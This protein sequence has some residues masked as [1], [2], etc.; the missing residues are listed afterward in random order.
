M[1]IAM[2]ELS[3][4][5]KSTYGIISNSISPAKGGFS[6]KAAYRVVGANGVEYFSTFYGGE[7][8]I[9]WLI[10]NDLPKN[11][12]AILKGQNCLTG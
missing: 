8:K 10:Y 9:Y 2:N 5:L 11:P 1:G 7:L 4:F 12:R 3:F 6:A